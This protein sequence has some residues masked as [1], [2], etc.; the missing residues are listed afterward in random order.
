MPTITGIRQPILALSESDYR[1]LCSWLA[2][3]D[4]DRW[5]REI[6]DDSLSGKLDFLAAEAK[7]AREDGA[8][9][10]L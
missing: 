2:K 5:D 7:Q 6:E 4:W 1:E 9:Q 3:L 10:D 8:L